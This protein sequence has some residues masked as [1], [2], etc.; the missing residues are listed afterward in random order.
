MRDL[1]KAILSWPWTNWLEKGRCQQ[2]HGNLIS[3][4]RCDMLAFGA[5]HKA[6]GFCFKYKGVTGKGVTKS[7]FLLL[8]FPAGAKKEGSF[9]AVRNSE[10][11]MLEIPLSKGHP[12]P[13]VTF[14][15][16]R[17]S[18]FP[19]RHSDL[20]TDTSTQCEWDRLS[21]NICH[22]QYV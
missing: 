14:V 17:S 6:A 19:H 8:L 15:Q 3:H 20:A 16:M 22:C 11:A 13:K 7:C 12:C 4:A 18:M 1:L 9:S 5:W 21:V 2:T 10:L